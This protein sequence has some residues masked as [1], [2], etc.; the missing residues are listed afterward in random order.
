MRSHARE[1]VQ[2]DAGETR[3]T[4]LDP[5]APHLLTTTH[6]PGGARDHDAALHQPGELVDLHGVIA[7]VR[8][9]HDHDV[10][11]RL[12]DT[13]A[14]GVRRSATGGV[15][16]RPQSRLVLR[17]R[18]EKRNRGVVGEVVDDQ[19][20][21]RQSDRLEDAIEKGHDRC[22]LVEGGD[23]DADSRIHTLTPLPRRLVMSTT[24]FTV[25]RSA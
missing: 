12:P 9:G 3:D 19:H 2:G 13:E 16:H 15:E 14:Q 17:V 23:H 24:G 5:R 25:S 21:R 8:H 20:L 18:L 6:V 10:S 22:A 1:E 7:P 4:P 11:R